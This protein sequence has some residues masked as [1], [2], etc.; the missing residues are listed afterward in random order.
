MQNLTGRIQPEHPDAG[1][2]ENEAANIRTIA[3]PEVWVY[4]A[5][6][7]PQEKNLV[8]SAIESLGG[9]RLKENVANS[10]ALYRYRFPHHP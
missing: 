1:W 8:L 3:S 2:A 4:F 6:F 9:E 7:H 10:A 5:F